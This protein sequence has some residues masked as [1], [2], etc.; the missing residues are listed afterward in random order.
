MVVAFAVIV[1]F[2]ALV[3]IFFGYPKR[4]R[5]N[6]RCSEAIKLHPLLRALQIDQKRGIGLPAQV[7]Y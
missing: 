6:L 1:I 2:S 7:R 3:V 4:L 5:S